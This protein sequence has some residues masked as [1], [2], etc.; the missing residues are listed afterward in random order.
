MGWNTTNIIDQTGKRFLITGAN[1]GIGLEAAKILASKNAEVILAVRNLDKGKQAQQEI[2]KFAPHAMTSLVELDL[3]DLE[4]VNK[5]IGHLL[6]EGQSIDVLINNAGIMLLDKR[7]TS[8]QGYEV[9]WA[10]NHLGHFTLTAG[11]LPLLEKAQEPRVVTLSSLV[12]KMKAADIYYDDLNFEN[13]Y[14]RMAAYAQSKLANVMFATEL[15]VRLERLGSK[16]KSIAAHPGYTATNLQQH[17]GWVGIVMNALMA[18]KVEMGV[19]PTLLAATDTKLKGGEYIG[20]MKLA[21]YRGYPG[22]NTLPHMAK[23][24]AERVKLWSETEKVLDMTFLS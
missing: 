3:S 18:Q 8:S 23:N 24:A 1:S 16:V 5:C 21:N 6:S 7:E 4:S 17:M 14:D 15:N 2:V 12:A 9:Q 11:L 10:T 22:M 20:P 19:L 13:S